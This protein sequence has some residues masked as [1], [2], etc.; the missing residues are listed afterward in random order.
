MEYP[1][2]HASIPKIAKSL[3]SGKNTYDLSEAL[4]GKVLKVSVL[5]KVSLNLQQSKSGISEHLYSHYECLP[6]NSSANATWSPLLFIK[7]LVAE[8]GKVMS[9]VVSESI[10]YF[11]FPCRK[12]NSL[13]TRSTVATTRKHSDC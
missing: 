6:E 10:S 2:T 12:T 4:R 11:V 3:L 7:N 8:G 9:P 1:D 13:C 5:R